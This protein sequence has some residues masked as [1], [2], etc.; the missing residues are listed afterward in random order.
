MGGTEIP[1]GRQPHVCQFV[2]AYLRP[3]TAA[4]L[5]LSEH[6][7]INLNP[8]TCKQS[9]VHQQEHCESVAN[10]KQELCFKAKNRR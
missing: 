2:Y 8:L 4:R 3:D 10:D 6:A 9:T 7:Q 5:Q 1:T